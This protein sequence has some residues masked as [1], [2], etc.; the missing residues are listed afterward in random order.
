MPRPRAVAPRHRLIDRNGTLYLQWWENGRNNRVSTRTNDRRAAERFVAQFLAGRGS[1]A[2]PAEP[3]IRE[4]V[5]GYLADRQEV[6]LS[7]A[8]LQACGKALV[9]HLGDLEPSHMTVERCR[10]YARRRRAEGHMVGGSTLRR[11]KATADGTVLRELVTLRAALRWAKRQ[12]WIAEEPSI[13]VPRQPPP[14]ER[15]LTR[16]EADRLLAA[17][18]APHVKLFLTLALHT[19][20]RAAAILA[21]TWDR[22]DFTRGLVDYGPSEGG[23]K[24]LVA[25]IN[26]TLMAERLRARE[27]AT[28]PHVIEFGGG[29]VRSVK[30][31]TRAAAVRAG[32][33]GVT[34]HILRHW[35]ATWMAIARVPMD[36][37]ARLLGHGDPKLTARVYAKFH[38]DYL[39]AAVEALEG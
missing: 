29:A 20:A 33:P 30:T 21:L 34:P 35:A 27:M 17:A 38:P 18:Q 37:I 25:P 5:A 2:P 11:K 7:F 15:W 4:I 1:P 12:E 26:R 31:G 24:R 36:E 19:A 6:V 23:K 3:T 9:R 22:V 8:T 32:L 16:E 13:P 39:R 14:R 10:F 28:C